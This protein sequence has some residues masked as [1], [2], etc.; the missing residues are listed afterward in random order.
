[1]PFIS[2]TEVILDPDV[3]GTSFEVKRRQE[4]VNNFGE[5]TTPLGP[6]WLPAVGSITPVGDN[7]LIREDAFASQADAVLVITTFALRGVGKDEQ[8]NVF[9][10]DIIRWEGQEYTV[11]VVNQYGTAGDGFVAAECVSAEF[12]SSFQTTA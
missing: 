1:M 7:S 6:V 12:Q 4:V 9:Q 5:S 2:V 8:D 3:A 11:M 10:P